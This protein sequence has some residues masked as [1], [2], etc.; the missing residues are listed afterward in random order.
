ME[1]TI[2]KMKMHS[3]NIVEGNIEKIKELFPNC[4]TESRDEKG[5][6][7]QFI[8]VTATV[9]WCKPNKTKTNY[10][11]GFRFDGINAK[12]KMRLKT[13]IK[14]FYNESRV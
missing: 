7:K 4:I 3:P 14:Q 6:V 13:L 8:D 12:S 2:K 9:R 5:N 1:N 10:K 11:V